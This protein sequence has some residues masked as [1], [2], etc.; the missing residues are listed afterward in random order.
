VLTPMRPLLTCHLDLWADNLRRCAGQ[1]FVIDFDNAGPGDPG[2][3]I[4]M[5]VFEFGQGDPRRVPQPFSKPRS[6]R[7]SPLGSAR[8][9]G[10]LHVIQRC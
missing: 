10:H 9:Y 5:V 3:E 1:P 2:R 7:A 6:G 4:A 8:L